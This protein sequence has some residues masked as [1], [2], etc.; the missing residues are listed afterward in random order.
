[1]KRTPI[2]WKKY[3]K[4]NKNRSDYN[5]RGPLGAV[6]TGEGTV[7]RIWSPVAEAV[8]IN[9]YEDGGSGSIVADPNGCLVR[10][11]NAD[12]SAGLVM[13]FPMQYDRGSGVWSY[14][15]Q[16][17]LAGA[18]YDFDITIDGVS[19]KTADPYATA[20]GINGLRSMVLPREI[21]NPEGWKEDKAPEKGPADIIYEINIREFSHN[22]EMGEDSGRYTAFKRMLSGEEFRIKGT[23]HFINPLK[24]MKELGVTHV[25]LL[26]SFDFGSVDER[27]TDEDFNWGYDPVNHNVPEGSFST[28][29]YSGETRIREYKEMIMALHSAGFRVIMDVVYN[30]SYSLDSSL[31][32][33]VPWYYYRVNGD[34]TM[35]NGSKCGNDIASERFM[36]G[37]YIIN[38]VMY[39]AEE[40]HLDGFRF[41]LMGL[42]DT[43]LMNAIKE[44]L[45]E[46]FGENEKLIYGEPWA[47]GETAIE[48]GFTQALKSNVARLSGSGV[49]AD[50][51]PL[52]DNIGFFN[53]DLRDLIKGSFCDDKS[54]GF[55][56]GGSTD[57]EIIDARNSVM[58]ETGNIDDIRN[59]P[60]LEER[61]ARGVTAFNDCGLSPK[62]MI[63]YVSSHDDHTLWDKLTI[64]TADEELRKKQNKLAAAIVILGQGHIFM[65][66]G[67][68][69]LRTKNGISNSYNKPISLNALDWES[70]FANRDMVDYYKKLIG[71]RKSSAA[72]SDMKDTAP[73]RIRTEKAEDG[74]VAFE[75]EDLFIV[76]NSNEINSY[77]SLPVGRWEMIL[78]NM[79]DRVSDDKFS[80]R[81]RRVDPVSVTI[82]KRND[83]QYDYSPVE[84]WTDSPIGG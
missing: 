72:L 37:R 1:M 66:S 70:S 27:K 79:D 45:D 42:L 65:L 83:T 20:S 3:Y 77:V 16:D 59:I 12:E 30:H 52:D 50:I 64:T 41:D 9:L 11:E 36:A 34:G 73:G 57:S 80:E 10:D 32:K 62:Q 31:Q 53:D 19:R 43:D 69:F 13:S 4:D 63:R 17:N 15:S 75:A 5:Y 61:I 74:L 60:R 18:Y 81:V 46:R 6:V 71:I 48:E 44:S 21:S 40:Y 38:S 67:E 29:P 25:Q 51:R 55:V 23:D 33:T 49:R 28:D 76:F 35:S 39:W 7:F 14:I 58:T 84:N 47:A 26:P 2:L 8:R 56:N 22:L 78:G 68:E 82:Y 54:R 24:Y